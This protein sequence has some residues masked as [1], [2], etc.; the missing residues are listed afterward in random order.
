MIVPFNL[1]PKYTKIPMPSARLLNY[2]IKSTLQI[3]FSFLY[4]IMMS[5]KTRPSRAEGDSLSFSFQGNFCG[6]VCFEFLVERI[7][8]V[9]S[10]N[11]SLLRQALRKVAAQC[12]EQR[13]RTASK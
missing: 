3:S 5:L 6:F 10:Q 8:F 11:L 2:K 9:T 7:S 1:S 13:G 4:K 12:S